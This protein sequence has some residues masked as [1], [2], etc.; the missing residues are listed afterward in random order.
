MIVRYNDDG[1]IFGYW[2]IGPPIPDPIPTGENYI[3]WD[4]VEPNPISEYQ[5]VNEQV[6]RRPQATLDQMEVDRQ[7]RAA[8][9][10]SIEQSSRF[11]AVFADINNLGLSTSE[12]SAVST[13]CNSL[14][15]IILRKGYTDTSRTAAATLPSVPT[16]LS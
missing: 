16:I 15:M 7:A 14:A 5:V 3:R 13:Y 4:G 11:S 6:V 1:S 8:V 10:E 12:K 9:S 2:T